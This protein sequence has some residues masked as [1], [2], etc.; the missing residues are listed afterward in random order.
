MSTR[1]VIA[2][3]TDTGFTGVYHHYDGYPDGLGTSLFTLHRDHFHGDTAAMMKALID[4]HPAGWST[5]CEV[6]F[7][8]TPGY[9]RMPSIDARHGTPQW[10][11][12]YEAYQHSEDARR[13]QCY[14]HG[15][16][17]D[18]ARPITFPGSLG[19][20]EFA[21]IIDEQQH[22]MQVYTIRQQV[23]T[24]FQT[25]DLNGDAPVWNE[26]NR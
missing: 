13:P 1:A 8:L 17:C 16:R 24:L 9:V 22:T 26:E 18:Q 3:P 12:A 6:D 5:I 23:P 20:C 7:T 25:V 10:Q 14:C 15:E 19:M 4:D 2:R 11:Q 21:Y